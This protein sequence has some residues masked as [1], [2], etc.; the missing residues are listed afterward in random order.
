MLYKNRGNQS[1][2][3]IVKDYARI[4]TGLHQPAVVPF[5]LSC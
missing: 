3:P 1:I 5:Q 4:V 2:Q